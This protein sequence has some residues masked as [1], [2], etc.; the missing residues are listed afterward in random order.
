MEIIDLVKREG[1][2]ARHSSVYFS[3]KHN[4]AYEVIVGSVPFVGYGQKYVSVNF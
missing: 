3:H 2:K 1:E 4:L